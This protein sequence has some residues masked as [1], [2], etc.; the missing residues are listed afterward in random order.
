MIQG[1]KFPIRQEVHALPSATGEVEE[2]E[3][4]T[5]SGY[6]PQECFKSLET[7]LLESGT[8]ATGLFGAYLEFFHSAYWNSLSSPLCLFEETT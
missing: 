3:F 6:L 4:R 8:I 2:K 1:H 5:R 7:S